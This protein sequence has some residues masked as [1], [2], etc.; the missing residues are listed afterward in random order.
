MEVPGKTPG[1]E[2]PADGARGLGRVLDS[3][4]L[5]GSASGLDALTGRLLAWRWQAGL[6]CAGDVR[7]PPGFQRIQ[8]PG[9]GK[10]GRD[11]RDGGQGRRS[12]LRR[13]PE[14]FASAAVA[15]GGS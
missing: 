7:A 8:C 3:G 15:A 4:C 10:C 6:H 1:A 11:G 12:R 13:E 5:R 9:T 14:P 2:E